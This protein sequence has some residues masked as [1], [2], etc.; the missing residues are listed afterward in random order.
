[1][2]RERMWISRLLPLLMLLAAVLLVEAY[3]AQPVQAVPADLER[4]VA[5]AI[6][7]AWSDRGLSKP[8]RSGNKQ[9]WKLV[10][11]ADQ[12][13]VLEKACCLFID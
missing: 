8:S 3:L 2:F 7:Y 10:K 11:R 12:W 13:I 5:Q 9:V 6:V 1:M 4:F